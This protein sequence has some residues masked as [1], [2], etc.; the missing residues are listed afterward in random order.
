DEVIRQLLARLVGAWL[1]ALVDQRAIG[2]QL[3]AVYLD[4]FLGLATGAD[5]VARV[6]VRKARLDA[7]GGVVGQA[8]ADGAGRRDGA[9]VGEARAFG[10][11][12]LDQ[13]GGVLGD[14]LHV[15]R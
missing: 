10:G 7:V 4:L 13:L 2:Q 12:R 11:Q 9:V 15:A 6:V 5:Q 3:V 14:F 8:Q 1:G